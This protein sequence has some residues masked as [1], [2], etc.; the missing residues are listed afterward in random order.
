MTETP[1]PTIHA[2]R[3]AQTI[4][5]EL[6]RPECQ[7]QYWRAI[8]IDKSEAETYA[9][10]RCYLLGYQANP[11]NPFKNKP[12]KPA[13]TV[14][15]F[16][17]RWGDTPGTV[18]KGDHYRV[19]CPD[20]PLSVPAYSFRATDHVISVGKML[21]KSVIPGAREARARAVAASAPMP[22]PGQERTPT[23]ADVS[24]RPSD[25]AALQ[26]AYPQPAPQ[27][28]L[29][30][31]K[32]RTATYYLDL[33]KQH[34]TDAAAA[35]GRSTV[36]WEQGR[37]DEARRYSELEIN[38]RRMAIY[39]RKAAAAWRDYAHGGPQPFTKGAVV[40]EDTYAVTL[41]DKGRQLIEAR[42]KAGVF[43]PTPEGLAAQREW[44]KS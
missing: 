8:P 44:E 31:E 23:A 43:T 35:E 33:A 15:L 26:Q 20:A 39:D 1:A 21:L 9:E 10:T 37:V 6:S 11:F 34:D 5:N 24:F 28:T 2:L 30:S 13:P 16:V 25:L 4:A 27:E 22:L 29:A 19:S 14:K 38:L 12:N 36:A 18:S 3:W 32:L 7:E 17:S 40:H 41:T 42:R